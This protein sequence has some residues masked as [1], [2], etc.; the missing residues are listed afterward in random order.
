MK[1][2]ADLTQRAV[3]HSDQIDWVPSPLP[4][5]ERRMLER[6][7]EEV[8]RATSIVRYAPGSAFSP[9]VHGGGEEFIV[10]DGV[11][12]DEMGDFP[13]GMY[14]RNPPG[15]KHTPSSA[16]GCTIFVKLRQML[17]DDETFVRTDMNE[18][19][20]WQAGREGESVLPLFQNSHETVQFLKWQAGFNTDDIEYPDGAEFF[21][22]DGEFEDE[23]GAY[24][25]GSWLRLP[26]DSRQKIQ[27][28]SGCTVY[29]KTGHLK[30]Q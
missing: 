28:E 1:I 15:S 6:D 4:G 29:L 13:T 8:A 19:S 21:V 12:S 9:H 11:F 24:K 7:G 25:A 2:H 16:P 5:V 26:P 17:P 10:L 22:M 20:N 23:K 27:V 30:Q 18:A 14:L 3:M